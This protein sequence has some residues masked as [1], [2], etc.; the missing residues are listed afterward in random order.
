MVLLGGIFVN[1]V[2]SLTGLKWKN[3]NLIAALLF[4]Y[5]KVES[6]GLLYMGLFFFQGVLNT[7]AKHFNLKWVLF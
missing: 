4:F 7:W 3:I 6:K 1:P 2:L 5:L